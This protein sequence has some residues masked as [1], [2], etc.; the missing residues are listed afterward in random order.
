MNRSELSRRNLKLLAKQRSNRGEM[1]DNE[2]KSPKD[3]D[4]DELMDAVKKV[5]GI[6]KIAKIGKSKV[7][8]DALDKKQGKKR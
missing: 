5:V 6:D 3:M 1:A 2:P 8:R 4:D 7:V